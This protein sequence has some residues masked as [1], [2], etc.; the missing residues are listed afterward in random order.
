MYKSITASAL[1]LAALTG[2]SSYKVENPVDYVTYRDQP[3]VKQVEDGMTKQR[4]GEV[5]GPPSTEVLLTGNRGSCNN[6][7]LNREG[8]EQPYYVAFDVNDRVVGK[9]F[10]T[11]EQHQRNEQEKR[12]L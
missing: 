11:C 7:V 12:K 2:C 6:Y 1:A 4:V 10:M 8:K 5:A 9:G 3:L